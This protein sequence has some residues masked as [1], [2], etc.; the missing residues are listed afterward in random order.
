MGWALPTKGAF[1][2]T[3]AQ[4]Y[5][6]GRHPPVSHLMSWTN[7]PVLLVCPCSPDLTSALLFPDPNMASTLSDTV[8][9]PKIFFQVP[10][11]HWMVALLFFLE[12][13]VIS[14]G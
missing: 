8:D 2:K 12:L 1:R 14:C 6:L 7:L 9:L 3:N 4:V 13:L 11:L 5:S 10:E